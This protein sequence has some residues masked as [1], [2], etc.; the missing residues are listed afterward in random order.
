MTPLPDLFCS[1]SP[2]AGRAESACI[3]QTLCSFPVIPGGLGTL[4]R[5][6][7]CAVSLLLLLPLGFAPG[8][9]LFGTFLPQ[10]LQ[11]AGMSAR[12]RGI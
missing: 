2:R 9:F 11:T 4:T 7:L 5:C 12:G 10:T 6:S 8:C 1:L 3:S